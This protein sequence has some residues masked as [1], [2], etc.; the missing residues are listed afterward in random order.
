MKKKNNSSAKVKPMNIVY[1][2]G[3]N[4]KKLNT[5]CWNPSRRRLKMKIFHCI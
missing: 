5:L 2:F 1:L 3:L 4:D